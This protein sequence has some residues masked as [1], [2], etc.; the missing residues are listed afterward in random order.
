MIAQ[1]A[2]FEL[3]NYKTTKQGVRFDGAQETQFI[4][5]IVKL[6]DADGEV[7]RY[8][9]T[10]YYNSENEITD[11][12]IWPLKTNVELLKLVDNDGKYHLQNNIT[13]IIVDTFDELEWSMNTNGNVELK[14]K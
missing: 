1:E 13:Q 12:R 8:S 9:I 2:K 6:T 7:V 3:I 5:Y 4:D 10:D 14:N 11:T